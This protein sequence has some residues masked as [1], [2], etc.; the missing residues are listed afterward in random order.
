MSVNDKIKK[1]MVE[2]MELKYFYSSSENY[3]KRLEKHDDKTFASYIELSK[4]KISLGASILDCGCGIGTSSYLLAKEGFNVTA[5][6]VSPLFISEAKKRYTN[7]LNLKFFIDDVSKMR[8]P[9]RS[10]DAVCSFDLLEHVID[11]KG[12]LKEMCR[13]LKNK[14][15]LI[16]F[17]PNH[18]DPVQHLLGFIK[19]KSKDE[20]KPWEAKSR[21]WTFYQFIR[22]TFLTIEKAIG[23]NNKIYNLQPV[24]SEDKNVCGKDFDATWLTNWFD[25]ENTLKE[26]GFSIGC[27]FPQNFE[28]KIIRMMRALKLPKSLQYFYI[29]IRKECVIIGVKNETTSKTKALFPSILRFKRT[30]H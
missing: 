10:F 16:I 28:D 6:D 14:G 8:F 26:L 22:T 27:V 21:M 1:T 12:V 13:V 20:Y 4:T 25:I 11:V 15:L 19:W 30:L 23:I 24:L 29:K 17:M 7:L 18:L 3:L 2:D 5:T 9:N